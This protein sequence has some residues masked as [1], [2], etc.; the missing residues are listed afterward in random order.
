MD[1]NNSTVPV[2][3]R[4]TRTLLPGS[5]RAS[6]A[7]FGALAEIR[8][9]PPVSECKL[10]KKIT[11]KE[12]RDKNFAIARTLSPGRAATALRIFGVATSNLSVFHHPHETP[13]DPARFRL[14]THYYGTGRNEF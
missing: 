11:P 4:A 6:R 5:A 9:R 13:F 14:V 2:A 8:Q 7:H 10:R 12:R 1:C 3:L